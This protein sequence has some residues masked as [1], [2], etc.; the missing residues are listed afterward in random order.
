MKRKNILFIVSL[1]ALLASCSEEKF[2]NSEDGFNSSSF[3]SSDSFSGD[4]SSTFDDSSELDSQ[5]SSEIS[6]SDSEDFSSEETNIHYYDNVEKIKQYA[7]EIKDDFYYGDELNIAKIQGRIIFVS[8]QISASKEYKEVN[9]YRALIFDQSGYILLDVDSSFYKKIKDYQYQLKTYYE[10]E[11]KIVKIDGLV[12]INV[13][14]YTFLT[15]YTNEIELSSYFENIKKLDNLK[16]LYSLCQNIPLNYKGI[17]YYDLININLKY[18]EKLD[19][20][21]LLMHDGYNFIK[22]IGDSKI[23]NNFIKGQNYQILAFANI[24]KYAPSLILV[25]KK[26]IDIEINDVN[27]NS[28]SILSNDDL[29]KIDYKNDNKTHFYD[30]ENV[31]QN[32]YKFE[33]YINCYL[34][35]SAMYMVGIN[36]YKT[37]EYSSYTNAANDKALFINNNSEYNLKNEK[38]YLSSKTYEYLL[39]EKK[40]S[41][42]YYPINRNTNHYWSIYI[43]SEIEAL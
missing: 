23:G 25:D 16:K 36:E 38:D 24:Y 12:Q 28:Y 26:N 5:S 37:K 20:N 17:G 4:H 29:Y 1:L 22:L 39:E 11:G 40:V 6:S 7:T 15:N 13:T 19:N 43:T 21:V 14:N 3:I 42:Y 41:F 10:I 32:I 8:D 27:L 33:G 18:Y 31:F 2:S 34:K 30:Y 9:R 35:N